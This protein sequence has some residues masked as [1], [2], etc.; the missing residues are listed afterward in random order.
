MPRAAC[1]IA[2]TADPV[3]RLRPVATP[4]DGSGRAR[5]S[6]QLVARHPGQRTTAAGIADGSPAPGATEPARRASGFRPRREPGQRPDEPGQTARRDAV[7]AVAGEL[8]G[9]ALSLQRSVRRAR[10]RADCQ[11]QSR[12]NPGPDRL[13]RQHPGDAC[14]AGRAPAVQPVARPGPSRFTGCPGLSGPAIRASG[15]SAAR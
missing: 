7:H 4:L 6:A 9:L 13:L 5:A 1:G 14:R 3:L 2:S 11:P 8:P 12:G 10:W 15:A